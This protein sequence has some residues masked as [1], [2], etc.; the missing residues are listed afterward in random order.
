MGTLLVIEDDE[1]IAELLNSVLEEGGYTATIVPALQQAPAG[2][3]ALII[4][5]LISTDGYD[6]AAAR[7][8]VADVRL[9]FPGVPVAVC[10]AHKV[11][12]AASALGAD[13]VLLKPFDVDELLGLV[14]RLTG[15][16]ARSAN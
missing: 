13:A 3:Y 2:D 5:D 12:D 9:A 14:E 16:D 6:I 7:K 15:G 8:W 1:I 10:T 11:A 4:T